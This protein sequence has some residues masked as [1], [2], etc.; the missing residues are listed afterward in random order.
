MMSGPQGAAHLAYWQQHLA[1][2]SAVLAVPT[3]RARR[4]ASGF[5]GRTCSMRIGGGLREDIAA[6]AR[7]Q[8]VTTATLFL[9]LYQ[10]LLSRYSGEEDIVV[11]MSATTRPRPEFAELVGYF[12]NMVPLRMRLEPSRRWSDHAEALQACMADNLDH[13]VYPFSALVRE[14]KV[15]RSPGVPPVFQVAFTFVKGLEGRAE[16][17]AI[18]PVGGLHQEGEY[19][20]VLEVFEEEAGFLL[21]LKYNPELFDEATI[22]RMLRHYVA[23]ATAVVEQPETELGAYRLLDE[24]EH[25]TIVRQWNATAGGLSAR[26]VCP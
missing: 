2:A 20:L 21:N 25:E 5:V 13:G 17:L 26:T 22:E 7:A 10:L 19:E 3:D 11:G 23:L 4:L 18:E 12:I 16:G 14:F 1:G 8:R 9:S 15:A 6:L 24:A